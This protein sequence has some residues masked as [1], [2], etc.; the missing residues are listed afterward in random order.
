MDQGITRERV[1]SSGSGRFG[2]VGA[3]MQGSRSRG[4]ASCRSKNSPGWVLWVWVQWKEW[5]EWTWS[6]LG[7]QG[8]LW[9][10]DPGCSGLCVGTH[11]LSSL[12]LPNVLKYSTKMVK[13]LGFPLEALRK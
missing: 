12:G 4:T 2:N 10:L 3:G 6:H 7:L 5:Q 13:G 8:W 9:V 11:C 1:G